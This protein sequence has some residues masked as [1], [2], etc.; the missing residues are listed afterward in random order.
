MIGRFP[1]RYAVPAI[2]LVAIGLYLG[3]FNMVMQPNAAGATDRLIRSTM[4]ERTQSL[5]AGLS[6]AYSRNDFSNVDMLAF[7]ANTDRQSRGLFIVADSG[8]VIKSHRARFQGENISTLDMGYNT[9]SA[10]A[11]KGS[12]EIVLADNGSYLVSA[13]ASIKA[14]DKTYTLFL[15]D[16][17]SLYAAEI[18][19]L[20]AI[21][22]QMGAALLLGAVVLITLMLYLTLTGRLKILSTA[23]N[24]VAQ[25]Q[26]GIRTGFK[27]NDEIA[28]L[29]KVFDHMAVGI[30]AGRA[31]LEEARKLSEYAS[32][33]KSDFLANM[34]HEIRTPLTGVLGML[35]ALK[36][37]N[38]TKEAR[39]FAVIANRSAHSL[40]DLIND[41]LDFSRLEA[42]KKRL[43]M[44][45]M[46]MATVIHGVY[47]T[48]SQQAVIKDLKLDITDAT[49]EPL[50]IDGDEKALRQ[51][52]MNFVSNAIKF[53]ESGSVKVELK[54]VD[55]GDKE[56]EV[57][58]NVVDT[59]AGLEKDDLK[60]LF[61]RFEQVEEFKHS[62]KGTG[63]GLA[64]CR[65]LV[66]LMKGKIWA[67]SVVGAGS[68]FS[69]SFATS[70]TEGF[71]E[72]D[73][74][75][76]IDVKTFK[77]PL[78]VLAVDDN[79]I[80]RTVIY[81]TVTGLGLKAFVAEDGA[82]AI[83]QVKRRLSRNLTPFDIILMDIHMPE[84]DG[85]D[86]M[87]Q[88]RK[89]GDWASRIPIIALTAHA[90]SDQRAEFLDRGMVG[91]VSKPI[92]KN[93]LAIEIART[94]DTLNL[95][96]R[97]KK[98]VPL[99]KKSSGRIKIKKK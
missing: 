12:G 10:E 7:Y 48:M 34:S 23:A 51:I 50:W 40:L 86:T 24:A 26:A 27:G 72:D 78:R 44:A 1:I 88:I 59:G 9:E 77:R 31:E 14:R 80:N 83:A 18:N 81:Q 68:I 2:L 98:K 3:F 33:A 87:D 52:L 76:N 90:F 4:L 21:P 35:E 15:V 17:Y 38:L 47:D 79:Q 22:E 57:Q 89:L 49:K 19:R 53:T 5:Q 58:L 82:A 42:G 73:P 41:I 30:D 92:D 96:V 55:M 11:A 39:R 16:D 60:R 61:D 29:G 95:L 45:P 94:S 6:H 56:I 65:E 74:L 25:G 8:K 75:T 63:L 93:L 46:N 36:E 32:R 71:E 91:Y 64:I 54:T 97:T 37:L 66:E 28:Q 67:E 70:R 84:M 99:K 20:T 43:R 62:Q 13:Y 85:L 69:M